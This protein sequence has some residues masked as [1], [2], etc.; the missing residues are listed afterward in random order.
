MER[1]LFY[2]LVI[3]VTLTIITLAGCKKTTSGTVEFNISK[4]MLEAGENTEL[5][6][7]IGNNFDVASLIITELKEGGRQWNIPDTQYHNGTLF[8]A[9][10]DTT[11]YSLNL[12]HIVTTSSGTPSNITIEKTTT[13]VVLTSAEAQS[14]EKAKEHWTSMRTAA[15]SGDTNG[16]L[17]GFHPSVRDKYATLSESMHQDFEH[18]F[19][20]LENFSPLIVSEKEMQFAV[21]R[22]VNGNDMASIITFKRGYDGQWYVV[23]M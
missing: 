18:I 19:S 15:D 6:W 23:S 3:L 14:L 5:S 12:T 2:R 4:G 20:T 9:P 10:S 13:A 11:E 17:S 16:V 7:K 22:R 8:V 1:S 21:I